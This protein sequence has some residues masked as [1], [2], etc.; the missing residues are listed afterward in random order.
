MYIMAHRLQNVSDFPVIDLISGAVRSGLT[1]SKPQ[2]TSSIRDANV[3][4]TRRTVAP[5]TDESGYES[6]ELSDGKHVSVREQTL[7]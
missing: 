2:R 1:P 5:Q 3:E 4:R 6:V 7:M